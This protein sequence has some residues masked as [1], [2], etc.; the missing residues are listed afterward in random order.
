ME[1]TI[2]YC[3]MVCHGCPPYWL[4]WEKDAE[5]RK[6]M[7]AEIARISNEMYGTKLI[8]DEVGACGGCKG[9]TDKLFCKECKIRPCAM[10]RDIPNCAHCSDYPCETLEPAFKTDPNARILLDFIRN[11]L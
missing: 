1:E 8:A 3:G 7:Q 2:A 6:R 9:E 4:G 5:K 10:A 11:T